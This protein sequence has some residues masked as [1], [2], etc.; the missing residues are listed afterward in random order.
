MQAGVPSSLGKVYL[1]GVN[2]PLQ[3]ASTHHP[4]CEDM[5]VETGT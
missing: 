4:V 2:L 5:A 1:T 3:V